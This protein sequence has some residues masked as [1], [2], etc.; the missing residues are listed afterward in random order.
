MK[1][2][3]EHFEERG[4][5]MFRVIYDGMT[6]ETALEKDELSQELLRVFHTRIVSII[7]DT[8]EIPSMKTFLSEPR[9][10]ILQGIISE[11]KR[12][13]K[14]GSRVPMDSPIHIAFLASQEKVE[15]L[16]RS[17][18]EKGSE[19]AIGYV[20]RLLKESSGQ[21]ADFR[22]QAQEAI[23]KYQESEKARKKSNLRMSEAIGKFQTNRHML[24]ERQSVLETEV[25]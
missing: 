10:A 22:K 11:A 6:M 14:G 19:A 4:R 13:N 21:V 8:G 1:T 15:S 7:K 9:T 12:V 23:R 2:S 16:L 20:N 25:S 24:L 17:F 18:S 5:R 3:Y